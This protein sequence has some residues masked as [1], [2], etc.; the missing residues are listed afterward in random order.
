MADDI[1][2]M[3]AFMQGFTIYAG[4]EVAQLVD[5]ETPVAITVDGLQTFTG[6][7]K[8]ATTSSPPTN[9]NTNE[10]TF[11]F[12]Q[13]VPGA[14]TDVSGGGTFRMFNQQRI[15]LTGL[16]QLGAA[17]VP[18]GSVSQRVGVPQLP[19]DWYFRSGNAPILGGLTYMRDFT[20]W[21]VEPLTSFD[22][23]NLW[24]DAIVRQS[25]GP[26]M[27]G[28]LNVGGSLSTT[29]ML[30][31]QSRLFV[32]DGQLSSRV[33]F[34]RELF[35]QVGGM[36][37]TAA[38]PHIYCTRVI[39]GQFETA[40]KQIDTVLGSS[41]TSDKFWISI[42]PSWE[43]LN[44]GLIEPDDLEY[45]TYMQRSVQAPGGRQST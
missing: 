11:D 2:T 7:F 30:S 36:G 42:P 5:G 17:Y 18:L 20:I 32:H 27:P 40:P 34:M 44:V 8:I 6:P 23:G 39:S 33:G 3:K 41:F 14:T 13:L 45:L 29:Q 38:A 19:G 4:S 21:S 1:R 22:L 10:W 25:A 12:M 43:L 37:E 24:S 28:F 9:A 26:N 15:D 31:S 16:L 35:S